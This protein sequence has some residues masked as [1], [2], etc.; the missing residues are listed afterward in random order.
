MGFIAVHLASILLWAVSC[1]PIA[2]GATCFPQSDS[3]IITDEDEALSLA[4]AIGCSDGNFTVTWVGAITVSQA[5]T[6][7]DGTSLTINGEGL[8]S[9]L[10]GAGTA[11]PLVV[12][13]GE[14]SSLTLR[15]LEIARG[16]GTKGGAIYAL[17]SATANIINCTFS[18]NDASGSGGELNPITSAE[19]L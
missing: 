17:T 12:V 13:E 14:S 15:N 5:L 2:G 18:D 7:A 19:R 1:I 6:I 8:D 16:S 3:W 9:A 4:S 10:D 11:G